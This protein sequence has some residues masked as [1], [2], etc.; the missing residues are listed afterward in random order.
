MSLK[1]IMAVETRWCDRL[2]QTITRG[3]D[4]VLKFQGYV[5]EMPRQSLYGSRTQLTSAV[6]LTVFDRNGASLFNQEGIYYLQVEMSD[7]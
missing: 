3:V 2:Y 5:N 1:V 6:F 7:H 4:V